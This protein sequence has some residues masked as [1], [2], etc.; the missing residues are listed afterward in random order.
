M[1][2]SD[3]L[4]EIQ[5]AFKQVPRYH[6]NWRYVP[7]HKMPPGS[8]VKFTTKAAIIDSEERM[9]NDSQDRQVIR[10]AEDTYELVAFQWPTMIL[11][12]FG[13]TVK[14]VKPYSNLLAP[15]SKLEANYDEFGETLRLVS[16]IITKIWLPDTN[17]NLNVEDCFKKKS[18]KPF[19]SHIPLRRR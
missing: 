12:G 15:S 14:M 18:R 1:K 2:N 19:R 13:P 16:G 8:Q 9:Y 10:M 7:L 5:H 4:A 3:I 6:S 17:I 11:H